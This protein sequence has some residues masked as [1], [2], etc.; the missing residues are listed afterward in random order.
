MIASWM[1]YCTVVALCLGLAAL[2]AEHLAR[3]YGKPARAVWAVALAA[4][5]LVPLVNWTVV[6]GG[7]AAAEGAQ[8]IRMLP[9]VATSLLNSPLQAYAPVGPVLPQWDGV[10]LM[11]WLV[12]SLG[13]VAL[14]LASFW[15][16]KRERRGWQ[17]AMVDGRRVLVSHHA[18]PAVVGLVNQEVVV[19]DWILGLSDGMRRAALQHEEEH[20]RAGDLRLIMSASLA[21]LLLPW[22]IPLWWQLRRLRTALEADCDG[23]VLQRLGDVRTY[24]TLLLEVGGRAWY[25]RMATLALIERRSSLARRITIMTARPRLRVAQACVA[26]AVVGAFALLA[27]ETPVPSQASD[28]AQ[29]MVVLVEPAYDEA[30]VDEPPERISSPPVEYPKLLM[31]AGIE[32]HVL[33][34]AIVG[35]DGKVEPGSVEILESTHRAFDLPSK[36]LLERTVFRPGK[37]NGEPVRVMIQLPIQFTLIGMPGGEMPEPPEDGVGL[38]GARRN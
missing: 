36:S 30:S 17:V 18:G 12:M 11:L 20:M 28:D 9:A 4:S 15:R 23:R 35:V 7:G 29:L 21:V 38:V 14:L 26:L 19:P 2:A 5:L 13:L 24:G 8:G 6:H 34:Q 37:V 25:P 31:D 1:V 32:G 22:N 16:I 33:L 27:C 3:L 10:L